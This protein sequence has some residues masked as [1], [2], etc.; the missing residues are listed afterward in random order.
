MQTKELESIIKSNAEKYYTTGTQD[1]SDESFDALVDSVRNDNTNSDILTTGWGYKPGSTNKLKHKY[2]HIGSLDKTKT[3]KGIYDKL[4]NAVKYNVSAKLDGLSCVLYYTKGVL[5][6]AIT[7]GDGTYG[8]DVTD[9]VKHLIS[10][11]I[12]DKSF[13]GAVRGEIFMTPQNYD[14]YTEIHPEAKNARNSA[15]GIINSNEI[16]E[17]INFLSLYVYTVVACENVFHSSSTVSNLYLWLESNFTHVAPHCD[18]EIYDSKVLVDFGD[19]YRKDVN[20]DGLVITY[21][22]VNYNPEAFI[23]DYKQIAFKFQDEVKVT[24]V[25]CIEWTASKHNVYVPVVVIEPVELEG[26][27]VK[28]VTGYNAKYIKDTGIKEGSIITVYKANQI[29]PKIYEVIKK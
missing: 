13:T 4:G 18:I 21:P 12:G 14:R 6:K 25:K 17:D 5:N 28:R 15:A 26:T 23:Y 24:T 20:I 22:V 7:R 10:S 8:Q 16:T 1:I 3:V 27:T 29:I 19:M 11:E 2:C 9:K